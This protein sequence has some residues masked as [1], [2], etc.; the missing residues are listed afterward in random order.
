MCFR[1][2]HEARKKHPKT[3]PNT[4]KITVTERSQGPNHHGRSA[5]SQGE[6]GKGKLDG[7]KSV[8]G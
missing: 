2:F 3:G 4:S 1:V 6:Q 8:L 5:L 7:C